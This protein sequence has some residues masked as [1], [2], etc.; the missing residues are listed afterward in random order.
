VDRVVIAQPSNLLIVGLAISL[1]ILWGVIGFTT[2]YPVDTA[3]YLSWEY[4]TG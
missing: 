2:P 1:A 4:V 3:P